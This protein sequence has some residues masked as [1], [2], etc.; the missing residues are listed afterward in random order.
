MSLLV[1]GPNA[2]PARVDPVLVRQAALAALNGLGE[3][4]IFMNTHVTAITIEEISYHPSTNVAGVD[5]N[6]FTVNVR[7]R[8]AAGGAPSILATYTND[9]LS[10]GLAAFVAKSLGAISSPLVVT[11]GGVTLEIVK[12]G[13]GMLLPSGSLYIRYRLGP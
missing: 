5:L 10:G 8:N 1:V 11:G 6:N 4:A 12:N 2:V 7:K 13:T 9:V 3:Q